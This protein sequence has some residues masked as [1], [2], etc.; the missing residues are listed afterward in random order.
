MAYTV[1][2][3][4]AKFTADS[5]QL[6]QFIVK[7]EQ[8]LTS[9]SEKAAAS[10]RDLKAAQDEFRASIKA[11]SAEGGDTTANLQRLADAEKNLA[12]AAAAAKVEHAALKTEL[13][14]TKEA[15]SIATEATA[16]LTGHLAS[17]FGLIAAAEGFKRLI[18]G[19]Q[20]SVLQLELLSEKTGIAIDKVAGIQHVSEVA[21][22]SFDSVSSAL[23]RLEK[24]Q[25]TALEGGTKQIQA[26]H[27]IGISASELKTLSPEE[28]FYR[29]ATAMANSTS[30]AAENTAAFTLL[31]KGGA[32]L[33][34]IFAQNGDAIRG[35]VE[36]AAKASGVTKEAALAA[37]DW[38][39]QTANLSEAWRALLIPAMQA[40]VPLLKVAETAGTSVAMVFR[41][42]GAEIGGFFLTVS[43]ELQGIVKLHNDVIHLNFNQAAQDAKQL[44]EQISGD[45]G[46]IADQFKQNWENS[47]DY[48]AKVWSDVKP[49]KQAGD[50]LSDLT[51]KNKK[52]TQQQVE[53]AK[54]ALEQQL[55]DIEKWKAGVHAAYASGQV[56]AADWQVAELRAVDASNI[57]HEN[58]LQ[59]LVGIY[60]KAGDAAKSQATQE[61]L[62]A[63]ETKD[64]AKATEDLAKAEEKHRQA[65]EKIIE[66]QQ[67]LEIAQVTKDF[68][69]AQKATE[70]LTKAE[71]QL[72]K[73]QTALAEAQVSQNFK[74]QEEAVK[75]LASLKLITAHQERE[76]L[77]AIYT[78][79]EADALSILQSQLAAEKTIIDSTQAKIKAAEGNPFFSDAQILD[80][81]KN[82]ALAETQYLKTQ[83]E[84]TKIEEKFDKERVAQ[85][86]DSMAQEIAAIM[87][88]ESAQLRAN[89]AKLAAIELEIRLAQSHGE[90]TTAL[91]NQRSALLQQITVEQQ[92]DA[93]MKQQLVLELQLHA[94]R[95]QAIKDE[96]S[97]AQA[98]KQDTTAL[99]AQE[100]E[101]QRQINALQKQVQALTHVKIAQDQVNTTVKQ[102]GPI[103]SAFQQ[104]LQQTGSVGMSVMTALGSAVSATT[105]AF[106]QGSQSMTQAIA[107]IVAAEIQ[108]IAAIADK[109][110]TEQLAEAAGSW[111]DFAAMA[112]HLESATLWFALG[113]A[114]AAAAGAISGAGKSSTSSGTG[115]TGATTNKST[116]INTTAGPQPVE[117]QNVQHFAAGGVASIPTLAVIGDSQH[118]GAASEAV[119]PLENRGA[120][121]AIADALVPALLL[122]LMKAQGVQPS[123]DA[124]SD[125]SPNATPSLSVPRF[126]DGGL[127]TGPLLAMLGDK[128]SGA[129]AAE[130]VLPLENDSAMARIAS[131]IAS[132]FR[133]PASAE[134]RY[135]PGATSSLLSNSTLAAAGS[136]IEHSL[137]MERSQE[138]GA[139]ASTGRDVQAIASAFAKA[140]SEKTNFGQDIT[141][142][143]ESDIPQ[144]VKKINQSVSTGRSRLLSSNSIRLTRRS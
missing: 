56:D 25:G 77:L 60:Q 103:L 31:G 138:H 24:A 3:G 53:V 79:E 104:E 144:L 83:T 68:K 122:A 93:A 6:D 19:T 80:L 43:D 29:V 97:V 85:M 54:G 45:L 37:R 62:N 73:A 98:Q 136:A 11:V 116:A 49:L 82:L 26:F 78:Q 87:G 90:D 89:Q 115:S 95:L 23:T 16:E 129:A 38:E 88:Y 114:V 106:A 125:A 94:A 110:G 75:Q 118:G 141:I 120:L 28:L 107:S 59:K 5:S 71:G 112:S 137:A 13:S 51:A 117:V 21:G 140:L 41:D 50:D 132:Q 12:L 1:F 143:L 130:A 14:G 109:K 9:A 44:D 67:K 32:A 69:A 47:T 57:A 123:S 33:I 74:A 39:K 4:V 91:V 99:T 81:K 42:L 34:P 36:E 63:L 142:S 96:I 121:N 113:G 76:Q 61:Q 70:E 119:I 84:I 105:A 18:E 58:Y 35:M 52:A 7:L 65:V 72:L 134:R 133:F 126:F 139:G 101:E 40:A 48:I 55:A 111:P 124:S 30:H 10:T 27:D 20:Q 8:G 15:A 100:K 17:M 128:Q 108:G 102:G 131:S 22:V 66:A 46:G 135:E 64:Q 86:R 92:H 2:D 127:V